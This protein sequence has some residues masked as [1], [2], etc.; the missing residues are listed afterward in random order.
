MGVGQVGAS[1]QL[2]Q[3]FQG[4]QGGLLLALLQEPEQ[5]LLTGGAESSKGGRAFTP[6]QGKV[7]LVRGSPEC[8]QGKLPLPE[9]G[10]DVEVR[11]LGQGDGN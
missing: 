8:P 1:S 2:R 10:Q 6:I 11:L 4:R 7:A 5:D 9:E 3:A